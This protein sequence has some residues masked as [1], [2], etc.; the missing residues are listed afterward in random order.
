MNIRADLQRLEAPR[1]GR[2]SFNYRQWEHLASRSAVG[3]TQ[4]VQRWY[5]SDSLIEIRLYIRRA[6]GSHINV[7]S[8]TI[9]VIVETAWPQLADSRQLVTGGGGWDGCTVF[10]WFKGPVW[11]I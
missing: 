7:V 8:G 1:W 5:W 10:V 3:Q 9:V 4:A 6:V 11:R 2:R